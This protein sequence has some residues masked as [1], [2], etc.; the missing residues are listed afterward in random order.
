[1]LSNHPP[2]Y[3]ITYVTCTSTLEITYVYSVKKFTDKSIVLVDCIILR[4]IFSTF[5]TDIWFVSR[6]FYIDFVL[7]AQQ[8]SQWSLFLSARL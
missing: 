8:P 2:L 1:M 6:K 3:A 7:C 4:K 5:A